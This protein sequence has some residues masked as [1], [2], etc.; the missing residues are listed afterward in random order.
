M[1]V[2]APSTSAPT[3]AVATADRGGKFLTFYLADEEYGVEILK[4]QEIIGMQPITR[5]PRT[6]QFIRGVIN[7][8]GKVIPIMD[9]R[10][11]FAMTSAEA[12]LAGLSD[13]ERAAAEALRCIIVVQVAGPQ[14][15]PVPMGIV[16]DRVSE[17][18][19]IASQDVEDA[20]SFGAGVKTEYL[21]GLGKAKT[22][23][24]QG[25]VKLLLDIDR[26]LAADELTALT[27]A[28]DEAA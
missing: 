28:Q 26:V 13:G 15:Q 4:V 25:R 14:G 24:G 23:D 3:S 8:R 16:V 18:A 2:L 22:A 9:L 17:V 1:S 20:P 11:R 19:A 12:A 5:V 7:L 6:P 21:L 27:Q 10:E